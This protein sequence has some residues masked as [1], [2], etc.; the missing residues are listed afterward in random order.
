MDT[1]NGSGAR[2]Q[3]QIMTTTYQ[4]EYQVQIRRN[5]AEKASAELRDHTIKGTTNG[6][7]LYRK[8]MQGGLLGEYVS[9]AD[10]IN[11]ANG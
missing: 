4:S 7:E 2:N 6:Y 3:E 11:A 10:A 8:D 1:R 9:V 5:K